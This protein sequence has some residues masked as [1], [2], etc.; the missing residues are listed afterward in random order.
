MN[1]AL[2]ICQAM[3][4]ARLPPPVSESAVEVARKEWIDNAVET[5]VGR[6][7]DV[8]F[9]R[10]L[11]S[12]QGVTFKEFAAEV[13]QFAINSGS[14]SPCAIG[15][16]VI[17]GILGD[18]SMA[19]DGAEDLLGVAEPKKQLEIIAQRLVEPLADDALIAQAEDDEL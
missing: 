6:C 16:M 19:R 12:P 18:R 2:N 17:A 5:L 4:D 15:E 13:E 7:I 3:Y 10:R 9:K 11:H 14:K 8:K 1:A